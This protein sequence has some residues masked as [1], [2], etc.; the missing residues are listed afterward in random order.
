M[1]GLFKAALELVAKYTA[2][3]QT[4]YTA[5]LVVRPDLQFKMP[6]TLLKEVVWQNML[7][8][9]RILERYTGSAGKADGRGSRYRADFVSDHVQWCPWTFANCMAACTLQA[10]CLIQK[11][12]GRASLL[13]AQSHDPDPLADHNPLFRLAR[14]ESNLEVHGGFAMLLAVGHVPVGT[15]QMESLRGGC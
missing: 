14:G 15:V 3:A 7:F 12:G 2:S 10:S 8:A 5:M 6:L 9:F 11:T 1:G 4:T 13:L